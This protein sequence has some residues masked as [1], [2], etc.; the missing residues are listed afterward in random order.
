MTKTVRKYLALAVLILTQVAI[1]GGIIRA[2]CYT[3][4]Y[5]VSG[6]GPNAWAAMADCE[7]KATEGYS[8]S[9]PQN[10]DAG[11]PSEC[12]QAYHGSYTGCDTA[13]WEG[14][15]FYSSPGLCYCSLIP[16]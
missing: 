8:G 7:A 16:E 12:S 14:D 6:W 4:A 3:C 5:H 15:A 10:C 2:T 9:D 1:Q 11:C 13:I